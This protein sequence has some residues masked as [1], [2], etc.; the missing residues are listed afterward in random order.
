M[1]KATCCSPDRPLAPVT[2]PRAVP[3]PIGPSLLLLCGVNILAFAALS[4]TRQ[5]GG[6]SVLWPVNGLLLALLLQAPWR[7]WLGLG[8]VALLGI[9]IAATAAGRP[10]LDSVLTAP[11][12]VAEALAAAWLLRQ[13]RIDL[14]R[15]RDLLRFLAV[16][17]L[18]SVLG[19]LL[20]AGLRAAAF[21]TL[22]GP[23][24]RAWV[25]AHLIGFLLVT[26]LAL[27]ALRRASLTRWQL[28]QGLPLLALHLLV[29][30]LVFLQSDYPLLFVPFAPILLVVWRLGV[31]GALAG[32]GLTGAVALAFTLQGHGPFTLAEGGGASLGTQIALLQ[33][34]LLFQAAAVLLFGAAAH[35]KAR[36][37]RIAE[38]SRARA[39]RQSSLL[40]GV[41]SSMEQGL[42]AVDAAGRVAAHNQKVVELF[43]FPPG[44][45]APG[46]PYVSVLEHL[47]AQGTYGPGDPAALA[48]ARLAVVVSSGTITL[49]SSADNQRVIEVRSKPVAGGGFVA[50]STDVTVRVEQDAALAAS[51]ANFRLLTEHSG[52]V[53]S[54]IGLDGRRSYVSPAA[55]RV[56]Y[57]PAEALVGR[58]LTEM[59]HP[60]DLSWVEP[61][62][63]ALFIGQADDAVLTYRFPRPDG[64]DAWIEE[65]VRLRR[66]GTTGQPMECV[67]SLRD[68]T[69][70]KAAE[71]ELVEAHAAM[72]AMARSDG[73]TGLANR[74]HFDELLQR[75]WLRAARDEVPLAVLLADVDRFKLYNDCY[76]HGA[77]DACLRTVAAAFSGAARRAGDLAARYGGEEFAV[78][79]PGA[80]AVAAFG[81][82]ERLRLAVVDAAVEHAGNPPLGV[83]TIS[84]GVAA[85]VPRPGGPIATDALLRAADAALYRAKAAGR[86]RAMDAEDLAAA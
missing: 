32:V 36:L 34:Y 48:A 65:H 47:A 24:V 27:A 84:I 60:D 38:A 56:L 35:L 22:P 12:G 79:L 62:L 23:V 8:L 26:P 77:G 39:L 80:D 68:A 14:G 58:P 74:R 78:L 44:L 59:V 70:R 15:L 5:V 75:E 63:G 73:L 83:V 82:A 6:V 19:G 29:V 64:S 37:A 54:R 45:L 18:A 69:D 86:N 13:R 51:E 33:V 57:W 50:T 43:R 25:P 28:C 72:E 81:I 55:G 46:R 42:V 4:L 1:A 11:C 53:I 31:T 17:L 52:D 9:M 30:T 76:G 7:H 16:A 3:A 49:V 67:S 40:A 85:V 2:L 41:L 61:T 66:D 21:G 20:V 10:P 71:I